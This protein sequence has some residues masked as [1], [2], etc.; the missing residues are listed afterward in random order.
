MQI[1]FR[2]QDTLNG[3]LSGITSRNIVR[4]VSNLTS[5]RQYRTGDSRTPINPSSLYSYTITPNSRA[6]YRLQYYR[7]ECTITKQKYTSD[8][9]ATCKT[10]HHY[11]N[12][13]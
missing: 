12:A 7:P 10:L 11:M 8:S 6:P 9:F 2:S 1:V 5:K 13:F 4:I 3:G